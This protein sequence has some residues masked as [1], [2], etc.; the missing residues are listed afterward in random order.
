MR[1]CTLLHHSMT[2]SRPYLWH[3]HTLHMPV[4]EKRPPPLIIPIFYASSIQWAVFSPKACRLNKPSVQNSLWCGE[5]KQPKSF[6][7]A[8]GSTHICPPIMPWILLENTGE[9]MNM[10]M[11]T[12]QYCTTYMYKSILDRTHLLAS[13]VNEWPW[14]ILESWTLWPIQGNWSTSLKYIPHR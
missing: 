13:R 3:T 8:T 1:G 6:E 11:P 12:K 9:V 14:L 7:V 5:W 2:P 4:H 10:Y